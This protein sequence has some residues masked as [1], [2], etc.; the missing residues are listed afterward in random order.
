MQ[1]KQEMGK[2]MRESAFALMEAKYAAGEFHHTVFDNV[3]GVR[4]S[5]ILPLQVA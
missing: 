1:I 2:K 5:H 3:E 4:R